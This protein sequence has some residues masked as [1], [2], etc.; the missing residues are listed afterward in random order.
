MLSNGE[1]NPTECRAHLAGDDNLQGDIIET[2]S[3]CY[4]NPKGQFHSDTGRA[5]QQSLHL[6]DVAHKATTR[7]DS[8]HEHHRL[9]NAPDGCINLHIH[10]RWNVQSASDVYNAPSATF[11][12][13]WQAAMPKSLATVALTFSNI[14]YRHAEVIS[15]EFNPSFNGQ[16]ATD[17]MLGQLMG[18]TIDTWRLTDWTKR[19]S[20]AV[21]AMTVSGLTTAWG[22]GCRHRRNGT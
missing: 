7:G 12:L 9:H 8:V 16:R 6:V 22:H 20:Q 18:P 2:D 13:A 15:I 11:L 1:D 14:Y 5:G 21:D 3:Q 4:S 10:T 19:Q 17:I